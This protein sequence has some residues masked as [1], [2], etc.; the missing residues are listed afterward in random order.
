MIRRS[1]DSVRFIEPAGSE[2]EFLCQFA[3]ETDVIDIIAFLQSLEFI[4]FQQRLEGFRPGI[5]GENI[6]GDRQISRGDTESSDRPDGRHDEHV[7]FSVR[8][9]GR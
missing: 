8:C 6:A 4:G 5:A 3:A 7:V 1:R 9:S 2:R